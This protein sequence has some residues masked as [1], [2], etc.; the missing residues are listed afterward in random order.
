ML[1]TETVQLSVRAISLCDLFLPENVGIDKQRPPSWGGLR[2]SSHGLVVIRLPTLI[3]SI[4]FGR[5]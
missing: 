1:K 4:D 5:L 3:F 2:F